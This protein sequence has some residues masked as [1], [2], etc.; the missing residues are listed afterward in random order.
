LREAN[1]KLQMLLHRAD[2]AMAGRGSFVS[3][4]LRQAHGPV[5]DVAPVLSDAMRL[6]ASVAEVDT[7]LHNYSENLQA[8]QV[9]LDRVRVVLLA[10]CAS[11]EAQRVHLEAVNLWSS[12]YT[13]T[14]MISDVPT[15][16]DSVE[17]ATYERS[18][19]GF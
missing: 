16:A 15:S 1:G 19:S 4:D 10:R 3:E 13:K 7:E 6:R 8:A 2:D 11:M 18:A 5:S 9:A 14:Q 17:C 12:A